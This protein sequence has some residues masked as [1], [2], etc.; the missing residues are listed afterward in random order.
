[1]HTGDLFIILD[2]FQ[3]ETSQQQTHLIVALINPDKNKRRS[4]MGVWPAH[5]LCHDA[6]ASV[7]K[8]QLNVSLKKKTKKTPGVSL[9][10]SQ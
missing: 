3:D 10:S 8:P 7:M 6:A 5:D 2:L 1:M 4:F 9:H